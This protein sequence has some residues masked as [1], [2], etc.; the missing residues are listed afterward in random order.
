MLSAIQYVLGYAAHRWVERFATD[1]LREQIGYNGAR[2]VAAAATGLVARRALP[3]HIATGATVAALWGGTNA[4]LEAVQGYATS[5][6]LEEP[7]L[8]RTSSWYRL[9]DAALATE[10]V[11]NGGGLTALDIYR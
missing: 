8:N 9:R 5:R 11:L 6:L 2:V 4:G 1:L 3:E 10:M 7:A